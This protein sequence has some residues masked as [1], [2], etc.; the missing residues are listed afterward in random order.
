MLQTC[1]HQLNIY[2]GLYCCRRSKR[3]D[4]ALY[5]PGA[6][7]QAKL[8]QLKQNPGTESSTNIISENKKISKSNE[9]GNDDV[10][11][12]TFTTP[13]DGH[14]CIRPG[15]NVPEAKFDG[16]SNHNILSVS[17]RVVD[18]ITKGT[19]AT[20]SDANDQ[21]TNTPSHVSE[22]VNK[23]LQSEKQELNRENMPENDSGSMVVISEKSSEAF[24]KEPDDTPQIRDEGD[25]RVV[26]TEGI[27]ITD[28]QSLHRAF[29]T[30]SSDGVN[31]CRRDVVANC[32]ISQTLSTTVMIGNDSVGESLLTS[33]VEKCDN[34]NEKPLVE[35]IAGPRQNQGM[36]I[37]KIRHGSVTL[38]SPTEESNLLE[39]EN[40]SSQD[41]PV[42]EA[43]GNT[44][45]VE[46]NAKTQL[47]TESTGA[48]ECS[49]VGIVSDGKVEQ[50]SSD[51]VSK[52]NSEVLTCTENGAFDRKEEQGHSAVHFEDFSTSELTDS[53]SKVLK[54][55]V[56]SE[57]ELRTS[58]ITPISGCENIVNSENNPKV[59]LN[60]DRPTSLIVNENSES[61]GSTSGLGNSVIVM[62]EK[63]QTM[64]S[65]GEGDAGLTVTELPVNENVVERETEQQ[66]TSKKKK[67]KKDKSKDQK[68]DKIKSKESREKKKKKEKKSVKDKSDKE[69]N[70]LDSEVR[71]QEEKKSKTK[72]GQPVKKGQDKKDL[73]TCDIDTGKELTG[74]PCSKNNDDDIDDSD[75]DDDNWEANF[76]ESGDCLNPDYLEEVCFLQGK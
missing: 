59:P 72:E 35:N 33:A 31:H 42:L 40:Q 1:V 15:N 56:I 18:R 6:L 61:E 60:V 22:P 2:F 66:K 48:A 43:N 11:S 55:E 13:R 44:I 54:E 28:D 9:N 53:P 4:Q 50:D 12:A 47:E 75:N 64:P 23:R 24:A 38:V 74:E 34:L 65:K 16:S 10:A 58:T 76:D 5:V 57:T 45:F 51:S 26:K 37:S 67:G 30:E 20:S 17:E 39:T 71:I 8:N 3:P 46:Q 68:E 27:A 63:V 69:V 29:K 52:E 62:E 73:S 14:D 7:R 32:G 70:V 41:A 19:D 36:E 21:P 25:E 49:P